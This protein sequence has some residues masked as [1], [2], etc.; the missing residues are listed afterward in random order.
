ML[1]TCDN[2]HNILAH[3]ETVLQKFPSQ[4][5]IPCFFCIAQDLHDD[6]CTT[7]VRSGVNFY[8]M[9]NLIVQR[10]WETYARKQ[11]A[12]RIQQLLISQDEHDIQ[13]DF[14]GSKLAKLPSNDILSKCFLAG[15]MKEEDLYLREMIC[16][17]ITDTISFDH[18]FKV[19]ANIGFLREDNVWVPQYNSLFLVMNKKGQVITWQ[20]TKGT[21]FVKIEPLLF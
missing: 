5:L 19:A 20:L 4:T 15:F 17:N 8:N 21:A 10:R 1:Y 12:F 3:D 7:L 6:M 13:D 14:W 2:N 11:D 18:T 9:E 16:T